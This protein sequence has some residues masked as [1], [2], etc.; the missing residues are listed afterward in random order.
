MQTFNIVS[1]L[2]V[3]AG[4][5]SALYILF[6]LRRHPQPMPIMQSV[7]VLTGL[8]AGT[9]GLWLYRR[10]GRTRHAASGRMTHRM[11]MPGTVRT[12][13][14]RA[15]PEMGRM[16]AA[17]EIPERKPR[18]QSVVRSTLHCGAGCTLADLIG[19]GFLYF[20]P[21]AVGGSFVLGGWVVDYLL[22]LALGIYFQYAAIRSMRK[23]SGPKALEQALKADFLSLTAWQVGMYGWMA[24]TIAL[25][26]ELMSER[27][28]WSF[29]FCMQIGM[30]CGFLCS[31]PV[32]V[33]LIR[34]GIKNT[35]E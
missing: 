19:E 17:E 14:P 20:V 21:V 18:W 33:L 4:L 27:M 34:N 7:W 24:L 11:E 13:P 10:M 35:M 32:N 25:W 9:L 12:M 1:A 2:C 8:W 22:A 5:F 31:Y 28:T 3:V 15:E 26:P 29:W 16:S 30:L 6:D 23:I